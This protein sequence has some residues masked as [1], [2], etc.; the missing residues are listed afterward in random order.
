M[1]DDRSK[2]LPSNFS[3]DLGKDTLGQWT[4]LLAEEYGR[5]P[6][7]AGPPVARSLDLTAPSR[8]DRVRPMS[9][10]IRSSSPRSSRKARRLRI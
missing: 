10:S 8:S 6:K 5:P 3:V 7:R 1:S 2:M 9:N 4:A